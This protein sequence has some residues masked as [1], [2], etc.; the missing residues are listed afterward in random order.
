MTHPTHI[1]FPSRPGYPNQPD[2][3][4]LREYTAAKEAGFGVCLTDAEFQLGGDVNFRKLPDSGVLLYRGWL[5]RSSHYRSLSEAIQERGLSLFIGPN[6]YRGANELPSW[7]SQVSETPISTWFPETDESTSDT[8]VMD[9]AEELGCDFD[10]HPILLK[11]YVK[12]RKQ[13]W[14]DA[15]F[16]PD[17]RDTENVIRVI[18]N[19]HRLT[20]DSRVGGLVFREYLPLKQIGTH[21]KSKMPLVNEWRTFFYEGRPFYT[22]KYWEGGAYVGEEAPNMDWV[23]QVAGH[24]SSDFYS[25]DVAQKEDG[26]WTL[27]EIGDG[28]ASGLPDASD[29]P[30]FYNR[31][32][33]V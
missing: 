18:K 22:A 27:I 14:F 20:E 1:L 19:F 25:A 24:V 26:S 5:V 11:D 17:P 7:Y 8:S 28:G 12:S 16:I 21:P 9:L 30:T 33:S 31:L 6:A 13:D 2:E 15:C 4:F 23:E 29:A 32:R 3:S 10:E